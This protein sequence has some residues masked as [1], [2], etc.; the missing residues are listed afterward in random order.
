GDRGGI[1]VLRRARGQP[2][3]A[4]SR[5][6]SNSAHNRGNCRREPF[7]IGGF[8]SKGLASSA[9][10]RIIPS[11]AVGFGDLP[12]S[13]N[14]ALLLQFVQRGVKCALSNLQ[15]FAGNLADALSDGPSMHGL[16]GE[17]FQNQ[18]VERALHEIFGFAHATY[19]SY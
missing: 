8:F 16:E 14:P 17:C 3:G 1:G 10:K 9:R 12:L 4:T 15:D 7:P 5:T 2:V 19:L 11:A 6:L 18:Q 13:R